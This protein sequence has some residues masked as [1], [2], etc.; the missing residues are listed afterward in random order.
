MT[1]KEQLIQEIEQA[2]EPVLEE[3]LRLIQLLKGSETEDL[4]EVIQDALDLYEAQ[5]AIAW[6]KSKGEEPQPWHQVK[7]ELG[8]T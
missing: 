2:S 5:T 6:S 8:L 1:V 4:V 7:A 3:T